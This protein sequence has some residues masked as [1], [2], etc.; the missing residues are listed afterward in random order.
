M[1]R[2]SLVCL[3]VL[4]IALSVG[5]Q[6]ATGIEKPITAIELRGVEV[7]SP[8]AITTLLQPLVGTQPTAEQLQAAFRAVVDWYR[9]RGYVLAQ[10]AGYEQDE[11]GKLVVEIAEGKIEEI[12]VQGNR[13]TRA[14][15]LRQLVGLKPGEVYN[16]QRVQ[17]IRQRLGRFP[18]LRDAKL[19]PEAGS[20]L[21]T[22]RLLLQVEE[23]RSFDVA[24]ALGYTSEDGFI[25]YAEMH[26]TN[27]AGRGHRARLQWQREQVRD[28]ET[29][30]ITPLRPS[31]A[32]SY[33]APRFLPGAFNFGIE[34]YDCAP[35]Y[36]VF[37]S[38]LDNLRRYERRRGL[39]AYVGLDW[40][41]L[42]ELRLRFRSDEVDYDDAPPE[43]IS[44]VERSVNRGRI[45]A[46]GFQVLYDTRQG[47]P[48]TRTGL[49]AT[50]LAER[51]LNGSDFRFARVIGEAQYYISFGGERVLLLR[52]LA[53]MASEP[54]PLSEKF[55]LG[56]FELLRG[57]DQ[58]EFRGDQMLLGSAEY[59]FP[60]MEA[61]QGAL[62][63]DV[64]TAWD[65]EQTLRA[66]D[67]RIGAG[68]GLRFASPIGI[69]RFDLAYGK[70]TFAYL[71]LST[72]Y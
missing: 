55:W 6:P 15:V 44:P 70:R 68:V 72:G 62:F 16:E 17:R 25:G 60:I 33:E 2:I 5:A 7:G 54:L 8:S 47:R 14:S 13:R 37:Y 58:D 32:L 45:N 63:V 3:G 43:L 69:I 67:V 66:R 28:P 48:F 10:V 52:G 12:V 61:V 57:Y 46:I 39:T 4:V 65:R 56:G 31:Y 26:E 30:E 34:V 59:R 29:G 1:N 22:T 24:V 18:F 9:Q 51:T 38:D 11:T 42:F 41:E 21:G 19:G 50:V 20:E 35:F 64:G 23:E 49:Y 53:G 71:S 36:P 27:I 40:R